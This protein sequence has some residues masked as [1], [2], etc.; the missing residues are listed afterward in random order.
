[1]DSMRSTKYMTSEDEPPWLEGVQYAT[2]E[3][4]K[5]IANSSSEN[6]WLG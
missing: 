4:W 6:T 2:K 1:M 5:A 3:E